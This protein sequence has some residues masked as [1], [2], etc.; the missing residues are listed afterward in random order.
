MNAPDE[1]W[2]GA[3]HS[4][5][6]QGDLVSASWLLDAHDAVHSTQPEV[7]V[8]F[9]KVMR[10]R[11]RHADASGALGQALE[12]HPENVELLLARAR[13]ARDFKDAQQ[14][15]G[16][17]ARAWKQVKGVATWV[18]EWID[19]MLAIGLRD[20]ALRVARVHAARDRRD[21]EAWFWLGYVH[22]LGRN[23]D[24]AR[25]A[26]R[27]C[28]RINPHRR[29]LRS[30]LGA[31]YLELHDYAAARVELE[32]ALIDD[33]SNDLAWSNLSLLLL[34]EGDPTAARVAAERAI[35]L[36]PQ[37]ACAWQGYSN[38]LKELQEWDAA[39]QAAARAYQLA[40]SEP[41][42][43]WALGM[44]QLV[45]GNYREGWISHEARW[46]GSRELRDVSLPWRMPRWNGQPVG[47][48]RVLVWSEQGYGDVLQFVRF[49]PAFAQRIRDAGGEVVYC[50]FPPLLSLVSRDLGDEVGTIVPSVLSAIPAHDFQ[51]PLGSLPLILGVLLEDLPRYA[52]PY[53][54]PDT[55]RVSQWQGRWE[56]RDASS[57]GKTLKVGLV[58]SG[59][60]TH[61]RNPYRSVVPRA[62]AQVLAGIEGV[63]FCSLQMQ[64]PA[65]ELEVFRQAGLDMLDDT[66][67]LQ[68]FDETAAYVSSL[69]LVITV[70]TSV[71][72]L[73][74]G[75][76]VPGWLLLDV[77]PHWVWMTER[78]D[79]PWYPSLQ[80]YR[81]SEFGQWAPVLAR[82]ARDLRA[83]VV[84]VQRGRDLRVTATG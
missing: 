62:L 7:V 15:H 46:Q 73:T 58:W 44:L 66:H 16:Y 33:P 54:R 35:V 65:E 31:I 10:M 55:Q 45:Q 20:E 29:P 72:H 80:L 39:C 9:S 57:R 49:L 70:C 47:G 42:Y 24:A 59:S 61:Q 14:A 78:Q 13:L 36:G 3:A 51:I 83:H 23:F 26:Y 56:S 22:H 8:L 75:L 30:N 68:S 2:Q 71:A 60:R 48:R 67:E 52:R 21:A 11:G 81:Q 4:A 41:L 64:A 38:A 32:Q 84:Q 77:N 1:A 74:G 37:L 5:L 79:S 18:P 17:F 6:A 82:V 25:K 12:R 40:P 19:V 53:L 50:A 34:K 28:Q 27:R 63:T 69:D 43:L 76:G